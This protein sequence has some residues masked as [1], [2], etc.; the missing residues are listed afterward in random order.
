MTEVRARERWRGLSP[1]DRE[2][3]LSRAIGGANLRGQGCSGEVPD[4]LAMFVA[5]KDEVPVKVKKEGVRAKVPVEGVPSAST[6]VRG[7]RKR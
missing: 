6:T 4:W 7:G 2:A 5:K 1:E 3:I